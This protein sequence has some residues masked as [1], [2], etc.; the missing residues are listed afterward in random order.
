MVYRI[1]AVACA[2]ASTI[3][4]FEALVIKTEVR[5]PLSLVLD[6]VRVSCMFWMLLYVAS[7]VLAFLFWT[8][9]VKRSNY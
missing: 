4:L 2:I 8:Y 3:F 6:P 7:A 9:P 5:I 1:L